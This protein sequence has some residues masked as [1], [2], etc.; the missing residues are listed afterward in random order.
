MNMLSFD[1][2]GLELC[3]LPSGALWWPSE[4]RLFVAD[5][6]FGK[7]ERLARRGGT[8]LPPYEVRETLE[9]LEHDVGETGAK[10]LLCLGDSFDDMTCATQ[11][12]PA[13]RTRLQTLQGKVD[14]HWIAGNHDPNAGIGG[15]IAVLYV[16]P[17]VLRHIAEPGSLPAGIA[18][19]LSGH[20]HPKHHVVTRGGRVARRCFLITPSRIILPAYGAYTG[21]LA[22]SDP[23]FAPF[24]TPDSRAILIGGR[25]IEVP[26]LLR[27]A[28]Q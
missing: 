12:R 28:A 14:W 11:M 2:A 22:L 5:L 10:E 27:E 9:R 20:F 13:E 25:P 7:S 19:E 1:F 18:G 17:L 3:A 24:L 15:G 26:I 21:G 16:G 23:A 8:L 6:H 4:Q